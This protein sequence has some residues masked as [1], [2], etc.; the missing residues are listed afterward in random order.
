MIH[1]VPREAGHVASN[2]DMGEAGPV[3]PSEMGIRTSEMFVGQT[4][5]KPS[6]A[7]PQSHSFVAPRKKQCLIGA[8]PIRSHQ[9]RYG[10]LGQHTSSPGQRAHAENCLVS[11]SSALTQFC[12]RQGGPRWLRGLWGEVRLVRCR[13][14][15]TRERY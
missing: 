4:S 8:Q 9:V 1:R 15:E 7:T 13:Q 14:G 5:A 6:E 3:M 10:Q 12:D 2:I 11:R